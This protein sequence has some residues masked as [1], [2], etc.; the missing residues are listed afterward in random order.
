MG[1]IQ[2]LKPMLLL[3][4]DFDGSNGKAIRVDLL[5]LAPVGGTNPGRLKVAQK[6]STELELR[7]EQGAAGAIYFRFTRL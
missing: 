3:L 7:T 1:L 2:I 5:C 4:P 6:V